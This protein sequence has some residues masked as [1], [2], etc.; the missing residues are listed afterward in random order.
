M[1]FFYD[2]DDF[3]DDK[4]GRQEGYPP[5]L[6]PK[7][8]PNQVN[9]IAQNFKYNLPSKNKFQRNLCQ[10]FGRHTYLWLNNGQGFWIWLISIHDTYIICYRWNG[11]RWVSAQ[12]AKNRIVDLA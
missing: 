1:D 7:S 3:R 9:K 11:E 5:S 6:P 10:C 8:V 12:I 2:G 4:G